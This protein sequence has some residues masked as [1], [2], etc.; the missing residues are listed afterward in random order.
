MQTSSLLSREF[1]DALTGDLGTR[2]D[3]GND[4]VDGD[5]KSTKPSSATKEA[6]GELESFRNVSASPPGLSHSAQARGRQDFAA[7]RVSDAPSEVFS[8]D[9]AGASVTC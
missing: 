5:S 2:Q 9:R 8:A 6:G 7:E 1:Q 3:S 4:T